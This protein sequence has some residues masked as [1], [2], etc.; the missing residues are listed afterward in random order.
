MCKLLLL[1]ATTTLLSS[2]YS[3]GQAPATQDA[4]TSVDRQ[5]FVIEDIRCLGNQLTNCDYLK[6][7]LPFRVGDA[8]NE[9]ELKNASFQLST[10]PFIQRASLSIEKGRDTKHV[11]VNIKV[12]EVS[13]YLNTFHLKNVQGD[14]ENQYEV[15][16]RF[17]HQNLLGRGKNLSFSVGVLSVPN[18]DR[19][20]DFSYL[21]LRYVDPNILGSDKCFSSSYIG[22]LEQELMSAE[23]DLRNTQHTDFNF[24]IGRR[25][26]DFTYLAIGYRWLGN[27][28]F[29]LKDKNGN[30]VFRFNPNDLGIALPNGELNGKLDSIDNIYL[31]AGW[32]T[33]DDPYFATVGSRLNI[34]W[35]VETTNGNDNE[36][37]F[38]YKKNWTSKNGTWSIL[39]DTPSQRAADNPGDP[40]LLARIRPLPRKAFLISYSDSLKN[41]HLFSGFSRSQWFVDV[42]YQEQLGYDGTSPSIG[43]GLRFD[44]QHFGIINIE[45]Q[46]IKND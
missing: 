25:L 37:F 26:G 33:E 6:Q 43:I 15:G 22:F 27:R 16:A 44:S 32:N 4:I 39:A 28:N 9:E 35:Q 36:V 42:G 38:S 41:N 8:Y 7:L 2:T 5:T 3:L 14:Q 24:S 40:S 29:E 13:P 34:T 10:F 17:E 30:G 45:A 23:G 46:L 11:V 19:E 20:A 12:I 1:I 21:R 18:N 31:S